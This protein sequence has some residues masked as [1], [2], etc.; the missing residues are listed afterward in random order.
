MKTILTIILTVLFCVGIVS[1]Q[2]AI[3]KI[4]WSK[5]KAGDKVAQQDFDD[6]DFKKDKPP[7]KADKFE[8]NSKYKWDLKT[9]EKLKVKI[10]NMEVS[11][12]FSAN[13]NYCMNDGGKSAGCYAK[14]KANIVS[15]IKQKQTKEAERLEEAKAQ[16]YDFDPANIVITDEDL[17]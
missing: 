1:A 8:G 13:Y 4:D 17:N 7:A 16:V 15:K 11:D 9:I 3:S 12:D 5:L 14:V 6:T 2:E 10:D